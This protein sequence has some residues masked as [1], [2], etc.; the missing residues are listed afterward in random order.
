[1]TLSKQSHQVVVNRMMVPK[2]EDQ[3]GINRLVKSKHKDLPFLRHLTK[4]PFSTRGALRPQPRQ[5]T[6]LP[7]KR[8][9]PKRSDHVSFPVRETHPP[10]KA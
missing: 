6:K 2:E 10:A 1:M 5:K 7:N 9:E 4:S 8:S 3:R